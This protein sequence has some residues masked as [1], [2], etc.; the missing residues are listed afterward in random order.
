MP[1]TGILINTRIYF[2]TQIAF[3]HAAKSSCF[4]IYFPLEHSFKKNGDILFYFVS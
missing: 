2:I 4:I 3:Y 1:L